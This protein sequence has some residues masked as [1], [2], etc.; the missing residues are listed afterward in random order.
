M[1]SLGD[2]LIAAAVVSEAGTG[3]AHRCLRRPLRGRNFCR[4]KHRA[5]AMP[6][7]LVFLPTMLVGVPNE[8]T[9]RTRVSLFA[10][11]SDWTMP[12][13]AVAV[14]ARAAWSDA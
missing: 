2:L 13:V 3:P 12:G 5:C 10:L 6:G 11:Q 7:C 4:E 9:E 1:C 14:R 8:S